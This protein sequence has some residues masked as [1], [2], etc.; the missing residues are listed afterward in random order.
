MPYGDMAPMEKLALNFRKLAV[1]NL[2]V[3]IPKYEVYTPNHSYD[4]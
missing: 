2:R 1:V 4:T 3:Q